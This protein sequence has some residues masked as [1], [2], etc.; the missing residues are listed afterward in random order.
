MLLTRR[1]ALEA[2]L[3]VAVTLLLLLA[4]RATARAQEAPPGCNAWCLIRRAAVALA[5]GRSDDYLA[6]TRQLEL[7]APDMP[8]AAY[9][10]ARAEA[11]T[12]HPDAAIRRLDRAATLGA[13]QDPGTDSAFAALRDRPGFRDVRQRLL[14]NRRPIVAGMPAFTLPDADIL[15][16]SLAPDPIG[17]GWFIGSLAQHR[18]LR[19]QSDGRM[20][21]FVADPA[22][23]RVVGMHVDTARSLL[24][25]ATW[26][27]Q[28]VGE[29]KNRPVLDVTR[30][31]K[32]DLATGQITR[33]YAPIDSST[34]HL[35]N[36]LV[37]RSDGGLYLTDTDAGAIWRLDAAGDSLHRLLKLDADRFTSPNGITLS[38]DE[39]SLYVGTVEGIARVDL[40]TGRTE[41]L[42]LPGG[43]S[44]AGIDGLY[45]HAGALITVQHRPGPTQVARFQLSPDGRTVVTSSVLERGDSLLSLPTTGALVGDRFYFVAASHFDRL[46][47]DNRLAPPRT[48][49]E[50]SVVRVIDLGTLR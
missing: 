24:W 23:L 37:I 40:A 33:T 35:F 38:G 25:F 44:T 48:P 3:L 2:N 19:R 32:V 4:P 17:G 50:R 22:L 9:L 28:A 45:W 10:H 11:L 16:E 5:D 21:E 14:D 18:V 8:L 26:A 1:H 29:G 46:G 34:S 49:A 27:P 43:G 36:D 47:V 41:R 20:T 13:T 15:P 31:F 42:T 12:G 30:L 7:R 39:H 6:A